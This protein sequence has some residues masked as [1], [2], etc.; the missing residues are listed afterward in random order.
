MRY[1]PPLLF[2]LLS[3]VAI[4]RPIT[5]ISY[6]IH[7]DSVE[8]RGLRA[9]KTRTASITNYLRGA[10]IIGLQECLPHQLAD[11]EN[12][13]RVYKSVRI[14]QAR[15]TGFRELTPILYDSRFW[16][17]DDHQ[18]GHFDLPK[19]TLSGR[20]E[21]TYQ[22]T[23]ARLI[24]KSG[25]G[26]YVYNTRWSPYSE[27]QRINAAERIS[28]HINA[29]IYIDEP[30]LFMGDLNATTSNDS[31]KVLLQRA[32]FRQQKI[33]VDHGKQVST[34]NNWRPD[35][36]I[37]QRTDHVF[38]SPQLKVLASEVAT[39][40]KPASSDHH[41]IITIIHWDGNAQRNALD[42][43]FLREALLDKEY[44]SGSGFVLKWP[45]PTNVRII[46][47]TK[48]HHHILKSVLQEINQALKGTGMYY[49]LSEKAATR[50]LRVY[51]AET[52]QLPNFSQREKFNIPPNSD[53]FAG[54]TWTVANKTILHGAVFIATDRSRG[55]FMRHVVLE[56]VT[57]TLGLMGDSAVFPESVTFSRGNDHGM[58]ARLGPM[59]KNALRLIYGSLHAGATA[60]HVS[61]VYNQQWGK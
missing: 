24:D 31:V 35:I 53:G 21:R 9:W 36:T 20:N 18:S 60:Q 4:C 41:P 17:I 15:I 42:M 22:C 61:K 6:N 56:E 37:G 27:D 8:D 55:E 10:E 3:C 54:L 45:G 50:E 23:W 19:N 2:L 57:Q 38:V 44:G 7:K 13:L 58:A 52:Q 12:R 16:K 47:G 48:E 29:R 11:L 39:N 25:A 40:G 46:G 14:T 34:K 30:V 28:Q 26:I 49:S 43:L 59:D 51:F 1:S 5:S 33:L 32:N